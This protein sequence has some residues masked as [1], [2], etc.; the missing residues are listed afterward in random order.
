MPDRGGG[1]HFEELLKQVPATEVIDDQFVLDQRAVLEPESRL[2]FTEPALGQKG[3]A[4]GGVAQPG[5]TMRPAEFDHLDVWTVVDERILELVSHDGHTGRDDI[6]E[7]R[8]VEIG[9]SQVRNLAG[10]AQ[11]IKLERG[12]HVA[13]N[14]EI[15]PVELHEVEAFQT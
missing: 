3:P 11:P 13:R 6:I 4:Y 8:G 9:D 15:P 7:V 14:V 5:N 2:R 12:L 10:A 1:E